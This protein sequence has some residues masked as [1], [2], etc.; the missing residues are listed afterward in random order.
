MS[1]ANVISPNTCRLY[2][3]EQDFVTAA[4]ALPIVLKS[5]GLWRLTRQFNQL[6]K[7]TEESSIALQY[8]D[9]FR[10]VVAKPP[11]N[12]NPLSRGLANFSFQQYVRKYCESLMLASCYAGNIAMVELLFTKFRVSLYLVDQAKGDYPLVSIAVLKGHDVL[13][14][15]LIQKGA[16]LDLKDRVHQRTA[17]H[18]ACEKG[19]EKA[20]EILLKAGAKVDAMDIE[21][22]KPLQSCISSQVMPLSSQSFW[23]W[24]ARQLSYE[25]ADADLSILN[26]FRKRPIDYSNKVELNQKLFKYTS[27]Q[28]SSENSKTYTPQIPAVLWISIFGFLKKEDLIQNVMQ[29][30]RLFYNLGTKTLVQDYNKV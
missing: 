3:Q 26:I 5:E 4:S 23:G 14:R 7:Q 18:F 6:V 2:F 10:V 22:T 13:V 24:L 8:V 30:S 29:V 28:L 1:A 21:G 19:K 9:R 17:M 27:P 16:P 15:W 11:V 25:N 12:S 20:L